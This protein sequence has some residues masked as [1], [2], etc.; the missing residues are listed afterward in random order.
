MIQTYHKKAETTGWKE[1]IDEIFE[2]VNQGKVD[3][4]CTAYHIKLLSKKK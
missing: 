2:D 3:A 1:H 4:L